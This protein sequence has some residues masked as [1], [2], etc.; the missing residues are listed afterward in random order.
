VASCAPEGHA[1]CADDGCL[2]KFVLAVAAMLK[3][4]YGI[5]DPEVLRSL[6]CQVVKTIKE[7]I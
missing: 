4:E 5:D 3:Q 1:E 2:E 6:S 7:N